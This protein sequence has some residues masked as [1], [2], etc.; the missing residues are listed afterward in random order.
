MAETD[1]PTILIQDTTTAEYLAGLRSALTDLPDGEVEEIVEDARGHLAELA[2]ELG[3][4]YDR[5]AVHQRLGTPEAYAAEL[6]AAAGFGAVPETPVQRGR[7]SVRFAVVALVVGA[8]LAGTGGLVVPSGVLGLALGLLVALIGL[9]AVLRDGPRQSPAAALPSVAAL[10]RGLR[11]GPDEA[12][13]SPRGGRVDVPALLAGLQPGWWVLRALIAGGTVAFLFTG[14][15]MTALVVGTLLGLLALPLSFALGA[16]T[17]ADRRLLWIVV[18]VNAFVAGALVG[19]LYALA[20]PPW[21]G[22]QESSAMPGLLLDGETVTDVRPFDAQG[23]PL[24]EVY[25][26]DQDGRPLSVQDIGCTPADGSGFDTP[27][28]PVPYPR[29]DRTPD[30]ATGECVTTA[31]EPM[32]VTVPDGASASAQPAPESTPASAPGSAPAPAPGSAPAPA[33]E[34][35]PEQGPTG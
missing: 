32:I 29:G 18:P 20:T 4:G 35:A 24:S 17:R 25:L 33:P 5:A 15:G 19:A 2:A 22:Y 13:A 34:S 21:G 8:L 3:D 30:P 11:T 16:R 6:R 1:D 27:A 12:D 26:F 14:Q 7:G 9:L 23:R 28:E 31:P 10:N